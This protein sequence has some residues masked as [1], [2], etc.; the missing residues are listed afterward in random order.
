METTLTTRISRERSE[1]GFNA[2]VMRKHWRI[3]E[4]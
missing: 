1:V 3:Y 2:V 4:I